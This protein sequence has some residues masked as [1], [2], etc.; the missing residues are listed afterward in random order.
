MRPLSAAALLDLW[1]QGAGCT[2]AEQAVLLLA[3]ALPEETVEELCR[4]PI[5]RRDTLLIGLREATFGSRLTGLAACPAC[6]ERLEVTLD[7]RE[8]PGR[9]SETSSPAGESAPLHLSL[10]GL[11][12]EFRLPHSL[13]LARISRLA[14][15]AQA[16]RALMEACVTHAEKDGQLVNPGALPEAVVAAVAG[17][18]ARADPLAD[19]TLSLSC[20]AC[21][22]QWQMLFDVVS[23]F[24][25]EIH[26]WAGRLVGEVHQLASAYGWREAEILQMSAWRRQRYLEMIH[27]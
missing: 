24:W 17:E 16:R 20:P 7:A 12:I 2:P 18:M 1:E 19:L 9:H 5:G 3:Y 21:G 23:Y 6:G 10:D 27:A 14:D 11:E 4:F 13:D 22:N 26:A 8:L 15:A 25:S